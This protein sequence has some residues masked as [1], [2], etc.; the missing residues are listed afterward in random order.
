MLTTAPI[1]QSMTVDDRPLL[2][3][4][5]N[6]AGKL[7]DRYREQI[8]EHGLWIVTKTYQTSRCAS[9]LLRSKSSEATIGLVVDAT[10]VASLGP[11]V[12]WRSMSQGA[13]SVLHED[14]HNGVVVFMCG[15][16]VRK[17]LMKEDVKLKTRKEHQSIFRG[18]EEIDDMQVEEEYCVEVE[19]MQLSVQK[20]H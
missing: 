7:V 14:D 4:V 8:K 16:Y 10:G 11:E 18:E 19:D 5:K 13:D 9:L 17:R 12:S 20:F 2:Q 15:F 6:N 3:W 1:T